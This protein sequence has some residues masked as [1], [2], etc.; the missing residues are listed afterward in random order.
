MMHVSRPHHSHAVRLADG[1]TLAIDEL[2]HPSGTPVVFLPSAPGSRRIDPDPDATMRACVRL[3]SVDRPGFGA[4]SPVPEGV[5][6]TIASM[7]DDVAA[8]LSTLGV[9]RFAVI[10][11]SAGGRVALG[12]ASRAA[13]NVTSVAIVGTPAPEE[14]VPWMPAEYRETTRALRA[15]PASALSKLRSSLDAMTAE[16]TSAI[17]GIGRGASDE[18]ALQDPHI[19]ATLEVM[20]REGLKTA[21]GVAADI[22]AGVVVPWGIDL[23]TITAPVACFY[24][25]DDRIAPPAHGAWYASKLRHATVRLFPEAGHLLP[26][27]HWDEVLA[28]VVP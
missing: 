5:I 28:A 14:E 18:R 22:V 1:R 3:L 6:P 2:G 10:G 27:T 25:E 26:L 4:S 20:L 17:R 21:D 8:A 15:D 13:G 7:T 11:W 16:P 9:D 12:L 24:G 23:S 19:V